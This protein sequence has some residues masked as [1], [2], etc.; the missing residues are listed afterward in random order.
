MH[1]IV[2][3]FRLEKTFEIITSDHQPDLLRPITKA[4]P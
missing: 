3:S 4:R 1:R 2:E